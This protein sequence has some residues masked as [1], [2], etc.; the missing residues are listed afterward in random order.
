MVAL[1][2]PDGEP[3]VRARNA[4]AVFVLHLSDG[5]QICA[6]HASPE[7]W[8]RTFHSGPF[9]SD[10]RV[11]PD[12]TGCGGEAEYHLAG[13]GVSGADGSGSIG[14]GDACRI[15]LYASAESDE[16]AGDVHVPRG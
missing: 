6:N 12:A 1:P 3:G 10:R 11:D 9:V 14:F 7:D 5:R 13:H 15:C 2:N 4:S 16:I 8:S